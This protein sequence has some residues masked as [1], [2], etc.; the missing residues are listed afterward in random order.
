MQYLKGNCFIPAPHGHLEAIYRPATDLVAHV[1]LVLHPHPL[2]GGTMHNKVVYRTAAALE[3]AGFVTLRFNFR[4]V[5]QSTG[6]YD[7]GRGEVDDARVALDF[8]LDHQPQAKEVLIAGFSFGS[9]V[10]LRLGCTDSRVDRIIAIGVPVRLGS[11]DILDECRKPTLFLHGESDE[12][13]PLE[14][15]V[16]LLDGFS[17]ERPF[18]LVTIP[19][20]GHFFDHHSTEL[21]TAVTDFARSGLNH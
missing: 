13:A 3:D 1:A 21:K 11:V 16:Q 10:G 12:I 6:R 18:Q 7:Q 20:A 5:G 2:H 4:G 14:P 9:L 17:H 19:G 15:L 8:L